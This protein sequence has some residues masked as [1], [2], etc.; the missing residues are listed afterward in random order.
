LIKKTPA[1]NT[2]EEP[3]QLL[4]EGLICSVPDVQPGC[5]ERVESRRKRRIHLSGVVEL[6]HFNGP[7]VEVIEQASINAHLAEVFTEG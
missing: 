5:P 7:F 1:R 4:A 6:S 3:Q 2:R